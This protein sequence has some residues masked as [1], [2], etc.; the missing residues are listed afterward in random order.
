[1][2]GYLKD[3]KCGCKLKSSFSMDIT[4]QIVHILTLKWDKPKRNH[5][6]LGIM[7]WLMN[8]KNSCEKNQVRIL[9]N[10]YVKK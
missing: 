6:Y 3:T 8:K 9:K 5:C 7:W 4:F 2:K 1:M 10:I